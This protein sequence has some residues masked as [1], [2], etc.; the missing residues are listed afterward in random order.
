MMTGPSTH[1]RLRALAAANAKLAT[2]TFAPESVKDLCIQTAKALED[3]ATAIEDH[4]RNTNETVTV[5]MTGAEA[6]WFEDERARRRLAPRVPAG[7]PQIHEAS[8]PAGAPNP[9]SGLSGTPV[10]HPH[11]AIGGAVRRKP[12]RKR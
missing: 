9:D 7:S 1:R 2:E 3:A 5:Q 12:V 11:A 8:A 4:H 10:I 6:I